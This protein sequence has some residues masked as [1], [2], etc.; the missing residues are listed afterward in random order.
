M[1]M[2][3]KI[4]M[5]RIILLSITLLFTPFL[6]YS[7]AF[8]VTQTNPSTQEHHKVSSSQDH[9]KA[10]SEHESKHCSISDE[11][12]KCNHENNEQCGTSCCVSIVLFTTNY[13]PLE[14]FSSLQYFYNTF[15]Q[16]AESKNIDN[17]L[18][19]PQFA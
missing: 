3:M 7:M 9:H 14:N 6:N 5:T 10:S 18:R 1:K 13:Q 11:H 12:G 4:S 16:H 15:K 2:P 17:Q 19:P 8:D